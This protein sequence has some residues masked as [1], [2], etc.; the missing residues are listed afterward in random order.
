MKS[1]RSGEYVME[2]SAFVHLHVHTEYSRLDSTITVKGLVEK[3]K[4]FAMPAVAITDHGNIDGAEAFIQVCRGSGIKPI[5]GCEM[6]I[7]DSLD[8]L[9]FAKTFHLVLLCENAIGYENLSRMVR[10]AQSE[11]FHYLSRID[12]NI[13]RESADGLIALSGCIKGEIPYLCMVNKYNEAI[14][15]AREYAEIF[16]GRFYL[17]LNGNGLAEQQTANQGLVRIAE[18][19]DLPVVAAN[20]CHYL[21]REDAFEHEKLL[22]KQTGKSITDP[23]H[24]RF[25]ADEFDFK[26]PDEMTSIFA[27]L[28]DAVDNTL[29]IADRCEII[30]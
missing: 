17:E 16:P 30:R 29:K 6:Y 25:S 1:Q 5:V 14:A 20:D 21:N 26:S 27:Y 9:P 11:G 22:C 10:Y 12:K 28:P 2:S 18:E 15:A 3:A 19:L 24:M 8:N 13:L 23:T 4:E 7:V